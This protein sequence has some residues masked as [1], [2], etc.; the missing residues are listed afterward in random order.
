MPLNPSSRGAGLPNDEAFHHRGTGEAE[1][2]FRV[3][4]Q[5]IHRNKAGCSKR[6]DELMQNRRITR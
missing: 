3:S 4:P 2:V 6:F 1:P 5:N